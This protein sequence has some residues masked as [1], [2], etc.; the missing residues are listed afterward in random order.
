LYGENGKYFVDKDKEIFLLRLDKDWHERDSYILLILL[1]QI[2]EAS[3]R[4]CKQK[5]SYD[6]YT[7]EKSIKM[8]SP[9]HIQIRI[10]C[11][12]EQMHLNLCSPLRTESFNKNHYIFNIVDNYLWIIF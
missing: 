12:L 7:K 10:N 1:S 2:D 8:V 3:A 4:I 5:L 6:A 11:I 9:K